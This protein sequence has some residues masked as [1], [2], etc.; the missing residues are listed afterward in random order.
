MVRVNQKEGGRMPEVNPAQDLVVTTFRDVD[1]TEGDGFQACLHCLDFIRQ[2]PQFEAVRN[3]GIVDL[4]LSTAPLRVLEL[5]SGLGHEVARFAEALYALGGRSPET[6]VVGLEKSSR[7]V[8]E[9]QSRWA[10]HQEKLPGLQFHFITG[11]LTEMLKASTPSDGVVIAPES[12][13]RVWEERVLQHIPKDQL[14]RVLHQVLDVLAPGG[15]FVAV[16]PVWSKFRIESVTQ[17][18]SDAYTTFWERSFNHPEIGQSLLAGMRTV[19]F[20]DV[21]QREV[22]ISFTT[23]DEV[24]RVFQLRASLEKLVEAKILSVEG[25]AHWLTEQ[26]GREQ[27]GQFKASLMMSISMGSR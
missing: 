16:E 2:L 13:D 8:S 17:G 15:R 18:V 1:K 24:D 5:G 21:T 12:M 25:V 22:V 6:V 26:E 10:S 11:D 23:L 14:N 9:A 4:A 20:R 27:S 19:G 3:E 7:F